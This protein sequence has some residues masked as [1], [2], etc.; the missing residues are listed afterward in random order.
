M[1]LPSRKNTRTASNEGRTAD[2]PENLFENRG[3]KRLLSLVFLSALYVFLVGIVVSTTYLMF[4]EEKQNRLANVERTMA[5]FLQQSGGEIEAW[6]RELINQIEAFA[7]LNNIRLFANDALRQLEDELNP[8]YG[9]SEM[10]A[11]GFSGI[12]Q[13]PLAEQQLKDFV[14]QNAFISAAIFSIDRDALLQSQTP[15]HVDPVLIEAMRISLI[16]HK[17]TMT[18]LQNQDYYDATFSVVSPIFI[19]SYTDG[20]KKRVGALLVAL[21]HAHEIIDDIVNVMPFDRNYGYTL[22]LDSSNQGIQTYPLQSEKSLWTFPYLENLLYDKDAEFDSLPFAEYFLKRAD[23]SEFAA[24][25]SGVSL[26]ESPLYLLCQYPVEI[27][28][29]NLAP[30]RQRLTIIGTSI[31]IFFAL[32]LAGTWWWLFARDEQA[33]S[34]TFKRLHDTTRQQKQFLDS[35]NASLSEG[36]VLCAPKT[37]KILYANQSFAQ[38][39]SES[40]AVLTNKT[41]HSLLSES[42]H[43]CFTKILPLAG[44]EAS[45]QVFTESLVLNGKALH[46]Q[47]STNAFES[48]DETKSELYVTLTFHNITHMIVVQNQLQA[49]TAK[50]V[51][52]MITAIDVK[53]PYLAGHT[54][55]VSRL[56]VYLAHSLNADTEAETLQIAAR[57]SQIGMLYIPESILTKKSKLEPDERALLN[58]HVNYALDIIGD[59]DFGRPVQVAIAHM[60][61][62]LDGSGYPMGLSG[63]AISLNG[64]ILAVATSFCAMLRPRSY[65]NPLGLDATLD[66]LM[67][68]DNLYDKKVLE[69]LY[70]FMQSPQ[71]KEFY[72]LLRNA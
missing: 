41:Y 14:K 6:N 3:R 12:S 68:L 9:T 61:E 10:A 69:A 20:E 59:I 60:Y 5:S 24:F 47:I 25:A 30:Y 70:A 16:T 67:K 4:A 27:F 22:L 29:A 8:A 53:D 63:D 13:I 57:L 58:K 36:I 40:V 17:I 46:Y 45:T 21:V 31:S 23:G 54:D 15:V 48:S 33:V 72:E 64:R 51:Q 62:R 7:D 38:M 55:F 28:D 71:G 44:T 18:P 56:S 35:I 49:L 19:P 37:G 32:I 11:L 43:N 26:P 2:R 52:S 39:A 50:I 34:K 1:K 42:L 66:K 65:H